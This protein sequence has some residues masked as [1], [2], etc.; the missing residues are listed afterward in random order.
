MVASKQQQHHEIFRMISYNL[1][2][3]YGSDL[4][5]PV[6]V[7]VNVGAGSL[8]KPHDIARRYTIYFFFSGF[9]NDLL[10]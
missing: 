1:A 2:K 3:S 4:T 9:V 8:K 7:P 10:T 5:A 6:S